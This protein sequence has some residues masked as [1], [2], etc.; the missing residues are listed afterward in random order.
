MGLRR[1]T[2]GKR[3]RRQSIRV[4]GYVFLFVLLLFPGSLA[5]AQTLQTLPEIDAY[6]KL[7]SRVPMYVQAKETR[8]GGAP[9]QAEFGPSI[10]F[11]LKP[12]I[13]LKKPT[14]FDLNEANKRVLVFAAGYRYLPS[15]SAPPENRW[16]LDLTSNFPMKA[17]LLIADRN[18]ADPDW[19]SGEFM[20]RYRNRLQIERR[21]T[22]RSFHPVRMSA[23]RRFIKS[24]SEMEHHR[25]FRGRLASAGEAGRGRALLR[26]S[27]QPRQ[28]SESA[29]QPTG[30][31]SGTL[32]LS[33][34]VTAGTEM[35]IELGGPDRGC[36]VGG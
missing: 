6:F 18:R 35:V 2:G 34:S 17:N 1:I 3:S 13:Q 23:P 10:Q 22:I 31:D 36:G 27:E 7:S 21:F 24:V 32:F 20:W 28:K 8:E 9:T 30:V 12:W 11:Y 29:T 4:A 5:N 16:R 19:Q 15:P 25:S 14:L 26:T 33:R